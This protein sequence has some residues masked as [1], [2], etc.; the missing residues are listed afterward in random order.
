MSEALLEFSARRRV[1]LIL[2]AEMNE[3]GLAC[4]AMLAGYHGH[5]LDMPSI[6]ARFASSL[7]GM[8]LQQLIELAARLGLASRALSCSLQ[9]VHNLTL[10]C[11]LHWNLNHFVVLTRAGKTAFTI[12]DPATGKC[13]LSMEEFAKHYT[14]I[15]LEVIPT[16]DFEHKTEHRRLALSQLWS[17]ITGL[18]SALL[19]MLVLSLILQVFTLASPYYMQLV[20]DEVLISS[21]H[22]LLTVLA[23]GF[24]LLTGLSVLTTSVRAWLILR[25]SSLLNMQMGVNLL[26]HLLHLPLSFFEARHMGDIVSRFGSLG[27]VRERL[28]TGLVETLVD[29]CM[30]LAVLMM[31]LLYSVKLTLIVVI[32]LFVYSLTRL[33]LYR[34]LHEASEAA[35]RSQAQEQSNFLENIRGIQSIKLFG[36]ETQRQSIWQNHYADVINSGI[37]LGKLNISF[38]ALNKTVFGLENILVIYF[39]ALLVSDA[40]LTIGMLLAFIAYKGQLTERFAN[41]LEQVILFRMLRLHLDRIS[42]IALHPQEANLEQNNVPVTNQVLPGELCLQNVSFGY[43]PNEVKL[44]D[45]IDLTIDAGACIAIT[46]ASGCGKSTLLKVM[47]GLLQPTSGRVL[48]DGRDINHIGLQNYRNTV[49]AVMQNDTLLA[50][51]IADNICYFTPTPI[52]E[53]MQRCAQMAAIH[54]DIQNMSMGYNTLIGDMSSRLSGGQLQRLFLARALYKQPHIL[55]LD[56]ATSHLD[57]D[58]ESIINHNINMLPM[59]KMLIAH[60]PETINASD[61]VYE[62]SQGKLKLVSVS[63]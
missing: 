51:T 60:R 47:L 25:L 54:E 53:R 40:Q 7:N 45:N 49:G 37:R 41:L 30:S 58:K 35:I 14:G 1:P 42:D 34:P 19:K 50:G 55:F 33:A 24:A 59:S 32:A 4:L 46:G 15:A 20:V 11:L 29:G 23:L 62:L 13:R 39:A 28:S 12:N 22:A 48:L 44:L 43:A 2:Q 38:E 61:Q 26:R 9:D 56:E 5:R 17:S 52:F 16:K 36:K 57:T 6:R 18:K 63:K 21:D 8:N 3:C 31:M 27:E 10:P